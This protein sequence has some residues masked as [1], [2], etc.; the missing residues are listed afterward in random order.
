[1]PRIGIMMSVAVF[2]STGNK[3]K[4]REEIFE[5][6]DSKFEIS[7]FGIQTRVEDS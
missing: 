4:K 7:K 6:W 2:L 1:V 5:I 3:R